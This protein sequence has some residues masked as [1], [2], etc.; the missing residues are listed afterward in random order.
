MKKNGLSQAFILRS[1]YFPHESDSIESLAKALWLDEYKKE[2][3]AVAVN[4]GYAAAYGG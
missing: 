1:H 4:K 2:Q 3:L